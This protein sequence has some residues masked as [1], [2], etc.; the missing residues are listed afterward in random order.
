M[1]RKSLLFLLLF[2]LL[3]PWAANAQTLTV[4][5]GTTTNNF[6]PIYGYYA[7]A[8]LKCQMV[9]PAEELSDMTDQAITEI[10]YYTSQSSVSLSGTFQVWIKEIEEASLSAFVSTDDATRVYEGT[11]GVSGGVMDIVFDV[12]YTYHGGN[13][14]V[15]VY[16]SVPSSNYP[17][18]TF[19]GEEVTGAT[20]QG[21]SYSGLGS[22]TPYQRDFLPKTTFSY[23]IPA[24]CPKPTFLTANCV[25]NTATV[26]WTSDATDFN[27]EVNGVVTPN[28]T[29]PYVMDNL[30]LSTTYEVRV[31]AI[32]DGDEVSEW[33]DPVSFTTGPCA[34][35]DVCQ[36]SYVLTDSYGDGWN[37]NYINV[38]DVASNTVLDTWTVTGGSSAS[39]TLAVCDRRE[40]Q[41]Q[42]VVA[43]TYTYPDENSWVITDL[44]NEVIWEYNSPSASMQQNYTVSC[45]VVSCRKPTD[46]V[47]SNITTRT[48]D[49]SWSENGEATEW[50]IDYCNNSQFEDYITIT[51]NGEPTYTIDE[52]EP[53]TTYWVRV[54]AVCGEG[55][56]SD[57]SNTISFTTEPLCYAPTNLTTTDI[58][59]YSA[60]IGWTS[61]NT[62]FE[63]R[64]CEDIR[65]VAT[66][67]DS[68]LGGWTNIDADGD[69]YEW[70][71][72]SEAA[73]VYHN[74]GVNVTG[75]G[76][77][78]SYDFVISGSYS[79][80]YGAL[81]PDNYLV[82][83]QV[84]LGGSISLW[85]QAQ[86]VSYPAEH[87]GIA[88][89]T[90][91]NTDAD[92]FTTIWETTMTAK[93]IGAKAN[94]GTTRSGENLR[95]GT[96]YHFTIDLS[97]YSGQGYVAIR[98]FGC[99]D[100]FLLNVDDI[101][102][103]EPG[104]V[105]PW[106]DVEDP[107]NPQALT[108]LDPETTYLV[109]VR[110][111]C[112]EGPSAWL[113]GTFTTLPACMVPTNLVISN[114][115]KRS[116]DLVWTAN[117]E[118]TAWQIMVN[119]DEANL[120]DVSDTTYYSFA[121]LE[122]LTSYTVKVRAV[123]DETLQSA[124]SDP[125]TFTTLVAC[126]VPT[127]LAISDITNVSAV[128]S[129]VSDTDIEL[130]YAEDAWMHYDDGINV[131]NIGA[132]GTIYWGSMFPAASL[133]AGTPLTRVAL[134]TSYACEATLNVYLGEQPTGTPAAT[135]TF[136]MAGDGD[137]M[138]ITLDT[139][140]DID[141]TQ[142]LWIT[143]Y[144]VGQTYPADACADTENANNRWVSMDGEAWMDLAEAG[145][146]G[147]GWMIRAAF[148]DA[149]TEWI[150]VA[151]A[152]SPQTF[153]DLDPD[154]KYFVRVRN[155]CGGI[156]GESDWVT[157][158]FTTLSNCTAPWDLNVTD[159]TATSA[160]LSWEGYMDNYDVKYYII[161]GATT[162]F[163]ADFEDGVIPTLFTNDATYP[164][165]VVDGNEGKCIQ[166]SNAAVASSTS[167]ISMTATFNEDG[168]I[169]FDAECKGEGS[170]TYYDHCDFYVD[171]DRVFYHGADLTSNGWIH[172]T[173]EI[174]AGEH[175]FTWSYTK[176]TSVNP[177]GD[178]FAIDNIVLKEYE[179]TFGPDIEDATSPYALTGLTPETE[180]YVQ[181][182]GHG[183]DDTQWSE[184]ISFTT[185]GLPTQTFELTAGWNWIST[186]IDMNEVDGLRMLEEKLGDY[187]VSIATFDDAADYFG[188]GFWLGLEDY[189][190]TNGE[191]IMVEVNEDCTVTL[192]GPVVDPT[193]VEITINPGEWTW[194]G[195]PIATEMDI[196]EALSNFEPE[197]L[198]VFA[199]SSDITEY[200][201]E[202]F[203][204]FDTLIPGQGYMYYSNKDYED[205]LIYNTGAKIRRGLPAKVAPVK[206]PT[207]Q[208]KQS[209]FT[210]SN[211]NK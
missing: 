127:D 164:W 97:A 190:W 206:K 101:Y 36:I 124:W 161:T 31:Q 50:E 148:G 152:A 178:Y 59:A 68:S 122:P 87:F 99:T 45:A 75:Q 53:E 91:G 93:S 136:T 108:G 140:V 19:Y 29:S 168:T 196:N 70:V 33:S 119:D 66:F 22:I 149:Q 74:A 125:V 72:G 201:G 30:A 32:C 177:S 199:N 94:P 191:M 173:F 67:D 193:T 147:Y 186:Y 153:T 176:D 192:E 43:G 37:G 85:A 96:W 115:D 16:E 61:D 165:I 71:L 182:K 156:D 134:H 62:N 63:M 187:G 7:D 69:G 90:T 131:D 55:D 183:C 34:I 51:V 76:H 114:I 52:L 60:N 100:Q 79:N 20:M 184:Y 150:P 27:I 197:F 77:N 47:V 42:Y 118:E 49:L 38:V 23:E 126:P 25:A 80:V 4:H 26:T 128:V 106:I 207:V 109:Q 6:V 9:Y 40:I 11:V 132:G 41:F 209:V 137:F 167:A 57:Y 103:E 211:S 180:Y 170:Y 154:T 28:V 17:T 112:D 46:L 89:S 81:T 205:T 54:H 174:P 130:E 133:T 208:E 120:I 198:D 5:D 194:I 2:A 58:T 185:L 160:S 195:F 39:G 98:H 15:G 107:T 141:G 172:Y 188:D 8:Y 116:A 117:G 104:F 105:L 73:G 84:T 14:L 44:N 157:A 102:I 12:P 200:M 24:S 189:M 95:A 210:T 111:I 163:S 169:E 179:F 162:T 171:G 135:Q 159:I 35:E 64:Y 82:S 92:D 166:S 138:E 86:D 145:L 139:P 83:P 21:Y 113:E 78:S 129:W 158:I 3:A 144:Q 88:V 10:K 48:A 110:A 181:V 56:E 121:G 65:P 123:C 13:L 203:G 155:I 204:D 1:K 175:T 151:D 18:T 202:W 143:F 142:N 146:P